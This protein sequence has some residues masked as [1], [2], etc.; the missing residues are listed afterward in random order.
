MPCLV[1]SCIACKEAV[2]ENAGQVDSV[3]RAHGCHWGMEEAFFP[4]WPVGLTAECE[5][6][7]A[8]D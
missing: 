4:L 2:N 7:T 5:E 6:D 8:R 1:P 3:T